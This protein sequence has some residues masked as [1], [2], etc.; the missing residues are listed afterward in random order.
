M[1]L[2]G[3]F[4]FDFSSARAWNPDYGYGLPRQRRMCAKRESATSVHFYSIAPNED[5]PQGSSRYIVVFGRRPR[6][7]M[8]LIRSTTSHKFYP[9]LTLTWPWEAKKSR[10][11]LWHFTCVQHEERDVLDSKVRLFRYKGEITSGS[12]YECGEAEIRALKYCQDNLKGEELLESCPIPW[13]S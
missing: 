13:G 6:G 10:Q 5:C 4:F 12:K 2:I 3:A 1:F 8:A 11:H 9:P 7:S